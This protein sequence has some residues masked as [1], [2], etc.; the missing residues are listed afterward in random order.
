VRRPLQVLS[1]ASLFLW[2]AVAALI[3][4]S[5]V[6][7]D[8]FMHEWVQSSGT[9]QGWR[10]FQTLCASSSAGG[11][12]IRYSESGF[13]EDDEPDSGLLRWSLSA[14]S[15][16]RYPY[17]TMPNGVV[18]PPNGVH[19]H[20]LG[21]QWVAIATKSTRFASFEGKAFTFPL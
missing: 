11:F 4:R 7:S 8:S 15:N 10:I 21:F 18:T 17:V 9:Q 14:S 13:P 1:L 2:L 5:F 19:A 20:L 16:P 12:S 3:G 6:R